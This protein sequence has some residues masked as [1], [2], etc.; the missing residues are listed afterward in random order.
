MNTS[1]ISLFMAEEEGSDHTFK[2]HLDMFLSDGNKKK[3]IETISA[4]FSFF[5]F[6]SIRLST[7]LISDS[8]YKQ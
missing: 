5:T 6:N 7:S 3:I 8:E 2:Q 4:F 1:E